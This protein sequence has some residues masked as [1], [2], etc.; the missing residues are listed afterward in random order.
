MAAAKIIPA[1]RHKAGAG[2]GLRAVRAMIGCPLPDPLFLLVERLSIICWR[3]PGPCARGAGPDPAVRAPEACG[4]ELGLLQAL[5]G[6]TFS[7]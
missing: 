2:A 5:R 4:R 1:L 7:V 6:C 3:F